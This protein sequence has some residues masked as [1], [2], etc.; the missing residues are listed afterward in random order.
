MK[1]LKAGRI[2]PG[3]VKTLT[4]KGNKMKWIDIYSE[5]DKR[6]SSLLVGDLA[7][8]QY[9]EVTGNLP[10]GYQFAPKSRDDAFNLIDWLNDWLKNNPE[11]K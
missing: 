1:G 3:S 8:G 7:Q 6:S 4:L 2:T 9:L 5:K 11:R 10:H